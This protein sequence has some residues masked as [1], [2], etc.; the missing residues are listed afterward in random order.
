MLRKCFFLLCFL[1]I[2]FRALAQPDAGKKN[3]SIK[4]F[5]LTAL[6]VL[7]FLPETGL[8]YGALGVGTFR[9][10]GELEKSRPSSVQ[11]AISATTK[12]QLLLFAPY[13]L[14]WKDEKWRLV[15]EFGFYKYFY[16][17]YGLGINSNETDFE[18]YEVTFPRL[19]TS[20]L[21]EV[22]PNISI[23]LGYELDIYYDF[24]IEENGILQATEIAGKNG[25]IVSN[26]GLL[27]FYDSRDD[28]FQPAEGYFV[29]AAAFTSMNVLG[30]S[31]S[32]SKFSLD[33][34]FYKRLKGQHIIAT[35][36]FLANNGEGTPLFDLNRL[37]SR[38]TRGFNDRRFQD[39]GELSFTTE[40]RFP[41]SGR[42]G[43][44]VFGSTGT[45]ASNFSGLFSSRYRNTFGGGM[46][47][48]INKKDGIRIR[49]DY[50]QSAEG[51]NFYFTIREA[52]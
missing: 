40:Y 30:S 13:E 28:I 48:T 39:N 19:R 11:F 4:N 35:N 16:N 27:V 31:F 47:Y 1:S 43:G 10:K 52:F 49:V 38:R 12:N 5:K 25:G 23:G 45:V 2:P 46:R 17:F 8:G 18:I 6:P 29:Q 15:G 24:K 42:F 20:L 32:Y 14:Y 22:W 36:L 9:F 50:G 21:N 33:A 44:V 7:F 37:G 3:D 34:R 26:L 51:G 41:V